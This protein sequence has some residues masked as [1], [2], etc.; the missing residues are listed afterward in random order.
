MLVKTKIISSS[1]GK[2][3]INGLEVNPL[4]SRG[5]QRLMGMGLTKE[6]ARCS[7][8]VSF[9]QDNTITEIKNFLNAFAEAYKILL[10]TFKDRAGGR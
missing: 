8:R 7:L 9:S 4:R 10:P 5:L 2:K 6:Q 1:E 3:I